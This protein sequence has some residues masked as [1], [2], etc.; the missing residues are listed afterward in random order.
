MGCGIDFGDKGKGAKIWFSLNGRSLGTAFD[1]PKKLV[2]G[3]GAFYPA[4]CMKNAELE[5][6]FGAGGAS[7]KPLRH[8]PKDHSPIAMAP[9]S[10]AAFSSDADPGG[11]G[12]K[13]GGF[14]LVHGAR[15]ALA[16]ILEPTR[17]LAEQTGRV[18]S[19]LC[20]SL[21]ND[22]AV[23]CV[24]LVGGTSPKDQIKA[25]QKGYDVVVGTPARVLDF[26]ESGK[27]KVNQMKFYVLDEADRLVDDKQGRDQVLK[28][29]RKFPKSGTG[30]DRLQCLMFSAT[31][32]SDQIKEMAAQ[33]CQNPVWVDLKGKES[34]PETVHH[35]QYQ[36]DPNEDRSWLQNMPKVETDLVHSC[37]PKAFELSAQSKG[38]DAMSEAVK[39]LKPR[40]LQRV[41]DAYEMDQC[42]IFCRTNFDCDR[43]E[44]FLNGLGGG[45]A[46]KSF[47]GKVEKGLENPYSCV[48]LAGARSMQ[49]RRQA[50]AA[51][52]DGDV[53]FLIC[54]DVAA[55]GIDIKELPYVINMCLPDLPQLED[56]IHRV[57]RVGRADTMGLAISIVSKVPE[58]VW[59]CTKKG[60]RPWQ[61]P[62]KKN[63]K[64]ISEGGHTKWFDERAIMAQVERRL[65]QPVLHLQDDMALPEEI[66]RSGATYGESDKDGSGGAS[67]EV[68]DR[69]EK[70][71]PTVEI[72]AEL[73]VKAQKTFLRNLEF[74]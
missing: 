20:R 57:G 37:D 35:V 22:P 32:H 30:E 26:V 34:V 52:K 24:T 4:L 46:T 66:K 25:L 27:L 13:L 55:R 21:G 39:R 12:G 45:S 38:K 33:I 48:V 36:V 61:E 9:R 10:Q 44:N 29:F 15:T 68:R 8:L 74:S 69:V 42:L 14:S 62:S 58:R 19:D 72:L 65:K 31:L 71:R 23:R 73:E 67:K 64:L 18:V 53:R 5:C 11:V 28:L 63:T 41:I 40:V 17:D 70:L 2:G 47:R 54:T 7:A 59:Y 56:Y 6:N 51:F 3:A 1:L 49:E 43:L 50:L 60:Y 16:L